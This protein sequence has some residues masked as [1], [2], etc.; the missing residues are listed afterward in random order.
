L[1]GGEKKKTMVV[2]SKIQE[3]EL[4]DWFL[5]ALWMDQSTSI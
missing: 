5:S 1:I 4:L 2:V 3:G